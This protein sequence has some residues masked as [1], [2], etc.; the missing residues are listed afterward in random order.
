MGGSG[1]REVTGKSFMALWAARRALC[2]MGA[3][4]G[5]LG[6]V[7]LHPSSETQLW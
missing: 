3:K 5:V 2:D 6:S 7:L 1:D 4:E